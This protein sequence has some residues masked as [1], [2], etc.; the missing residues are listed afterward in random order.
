MKHCENI[1]V[2]RLY[3]LFNSSL[4]LKTKEEVFIYFFIIKFFGIN[5]FFLCLCNNELRFSI[6]YT[7]KPSKCEQTTFDIRWSSH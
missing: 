4:R 2:S 5:A 1:Q 6:E 3:C 7:P